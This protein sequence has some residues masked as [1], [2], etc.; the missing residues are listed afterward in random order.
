MDSNSRQAGEETPSAKHSV[1][2]V[3]YE[4]RKRSHAS[5]RAVCAVRD[6]PAIVEG[7]VDGARN[8]DGEI[9]MVVV[10]PDQ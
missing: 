3:S 5:L 10:G 1:T 4:A 8:Q 9:P 7:G 2:A 6:D